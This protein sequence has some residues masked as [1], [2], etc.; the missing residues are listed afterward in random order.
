MAALLRSTPVRTVLSLWA[1]FALAVT[2]V[3]MVPVVAVVWLLTAPF[4]P[5][6]YRAGRALRLIG[7]AAA[8]LNPLWHFTVSGAVPADPR[9]PY[10]AVANHESF[11]DILLISHLPFEMKWMSKS[12]FFRYPL[13]GWMMWLARDIRLHRGD[14]KSGVQAAW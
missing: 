14:K 2:I 7:V 3:V 4:D 5:G 11:V 13:V 6:R 12:E 10:V 1:W 9:R 8:K